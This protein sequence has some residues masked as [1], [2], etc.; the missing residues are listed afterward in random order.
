MVVLRIL[1]AMLLL[2]ACATAPAHKQPAA[3]R[4]TPSDAFAMRKPEQISRANDAKL[5][6]LRAVPAAKTSSE[7]GPRAGRPDPIER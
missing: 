3:V 5:G 2:S 4:P 7:A 1:T 6:E